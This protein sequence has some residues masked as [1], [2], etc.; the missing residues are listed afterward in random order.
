MAATGLPY[1]IG[2]LEDGGCRIPWDLAGQLDLR[3]MH[4]LFG[5]P[6][7]REAF[8]SPRRQGS[9]MEDHGNRPGVMVVARSTVRR[10][11]GVPVTRVPIAQHDSAGLSLSPTPSSSRHISS[12]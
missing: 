6:S 4:Q 3:D 9:G 11:M 8:E 10:F 5:P 7:H 1:S 12:R 2:L